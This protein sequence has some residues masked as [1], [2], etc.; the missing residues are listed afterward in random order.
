MVIQFL[1]WA[2]LLSQLQHLV[3]DE[4]CIAA[5]KLYQ[6]HKRRGGAG[7]IC[8]TAN[9]RLHR[10]AAYQRKAEKLLA[11]EN[12]FKMFIVSFNICSVTTSLELCLDES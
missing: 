9:Q 7:G 11:Q 1:T 6:T 4:P 5:E 2:L 3:S 8:S 10:E 12:C